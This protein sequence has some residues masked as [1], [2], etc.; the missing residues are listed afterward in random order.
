M[1]NIKVIKIL[2]LKQQLGYLH[3]KQVSEKCGKKK[4]SACNVF[5]SQ[6]KTFIKPLK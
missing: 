1:C 6:K 2:S 3:L 4:P 5:L